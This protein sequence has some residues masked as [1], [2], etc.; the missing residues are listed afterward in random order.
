[1]TMNLIIKEINMIFKIIQLIFMN[2][3]QLKFQ[4]KTLKK[5]KKK[6]KF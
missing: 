6:K 2:N 4:N 5:K 1:M 3:Y